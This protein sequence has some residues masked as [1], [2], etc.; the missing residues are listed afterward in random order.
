MLR[1]RLFLG[2]LIIAALV[3]LCW[4]DGHATV[5]GAWLLPVVIAATVL[6]TKEVLDLLAFAGMRPLRWLVHLANL[7]L[8]AGTWSM[9]CEVVFRNFTLHG[10]SWA[11]L[12]ARLTLPESAV[13]AMLF[14]MCLAE[15]LRYRQPGGATANIAGGVLAF[16]YVG[17]MLQ[18]ALFL[19]LLL[20]VGALA[21]WIIVVKMGDT[22]AYTV[23]RLIGRHKMCPRISPGK[24]IEGAV[25]GLLFS[26]VASW[27]AF[28][29]LIP[30]CNPEKRLLAPWW[31]WIVFGLLV[32]A[33]GMFG[34]LAESL[35]KRDV[36]RKDSSD[37]LPG[38]GGVLDILD[39]LLLSAPV[40][41]FCW[42]SGL[43]GRFLLK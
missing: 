18:Y 8:V 34:D 30:L 9:Y 33:A 40:A 13:C 36:G 27:A 31:A 22:G 37:W 39:S 1:W 24:T 23:G 3:G 12:V 17:V 28:G 4:L 5:P 41:W 32:G 25:G 21:T 35:L 29:W 38:F 11:S 42:T 7:A 20:G 15:M 6:A 10:P 19:R 14:A 16:L 43:A 26:C 2:T